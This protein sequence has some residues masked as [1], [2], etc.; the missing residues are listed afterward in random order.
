MLKSYNVSMKLAAFFVEF[1]SL[2]V[3]KV[4]QSYFVRTNKHF[5]YTYSVCF[6]SYASALHKDIQ[7]Y[8]M[9]L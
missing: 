6:T 7:S 4:V 5:D 2:I 9:L 3:P 8:R 1:L